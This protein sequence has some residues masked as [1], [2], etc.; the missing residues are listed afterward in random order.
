MSPFLL[1]SSRRF[2]PRK[3]VYFLLEFTLLL[4]L[5]RA[6][7]HAVKAPLAREGYEKRVIQPQIIPISKSIGVRG[8]S[9]VVVGVSGAAFT[10]RRRK[11]QEPD[12]MVSG[13]GLTSDP[14]PDPLEVETEKETR[15][16]Q[17]DDCASPS[18][19]KLDQVIMTENDNGNDELD[20][21]VSTIQKAHLGMLN[22]DVFSFANL[23]IVMFV[24]LTFSTTFCRII[25]DIR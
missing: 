14:Q 7:A 22:R 13:E 16:L 11:H 2:I 12:G 4:S 25:A 20:D 8:V 21:F 18:V 17:E 6:P 15:F 1:S 19:E 3:A 9:V 10:I 24:R 5:W 23:G